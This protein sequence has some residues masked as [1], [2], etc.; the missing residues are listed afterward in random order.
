MKRAIAVKRAWL[1]IAVAAL[2]AADIGAAVARTKAVDYQRRCSLLDFFDLS[3]PPP[4]RWNGASPPVYVDGEFV[5]QD[6]DP[7]IRLMIKRENEIL[8][9]GI[10]PP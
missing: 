8:I 9:D 10:K 7:F 6:P 4:K 5:G 3:C 1:W 2:L